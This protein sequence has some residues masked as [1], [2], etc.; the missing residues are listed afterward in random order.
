MRVNLEPI[1]LEPG[2]QARLWNLQQFGLNPR[3]RLAVTHRER[4]RPLQGPLRP[5]CAH[6]LVMAHGG[7]SL[8]LLEFHVDP[9]AQF[10]RRPESRRAL[11]QGAL[12]HRQRPNHG[13]HCRVVLVP[14]LRRWVHRRQIPLVALLDFVPFQGGGGFHGHMHRQVGVGGPAF[15]EARPSRLTPAATPASVAALAVAR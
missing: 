5:R 9:V 2:F 13:F 14:S 8:Q 6:V 1:L 7:V 12:A 15:A 10:E 4:L 3:R 11:A